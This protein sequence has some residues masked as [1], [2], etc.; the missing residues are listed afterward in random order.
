M[1][2][3]SIGRRMPT[4]AAGVL[5]VA[6]CGLAFGA[7][8]MNPTAS[9]IPFP[10]ALT[11]AEIRVVGLNSLLDDAL[12]IGNGDINALIWTDRGA[13]A[14][15]LT[16]NDV[17]DGRLLTENDPPLP[18]LSRI[19]ALGRSGKPIKDPIL[20]EGVTWSG[21]DSY[22][23]HPYPCPRACARLVLGRAGRT[24]WHAIREQGAH[25]AWQ[26]RG[27]VTVMS[28]EGNKG[29]SNGYACGPLDLSTDDY[30]R[31][32]VR[33]SGSENARYFVDVMAP[34]R[35]NV[36]N[37][38]WIDSPTEPTERVFDLPAG[39]RIGELILYTWTEDG[40][41]AENRFEAVTFEGAKGR[42][43]IDLTLT[44]PSTCAG[45]L[46]LRRAA[47]FVKGA[48][49]GPAKAEIR[50]LDDRN[51]F[52][53]R[54]PVDVQ[55]VD[56]KNK[57]LPAV[58]R[59][60]REGATWFEQTLPGDP[61]WPGMRFAV[62]LATRGDDKAVAI[63]TSSES[64]DPARAAVELARSVLAADRSQLIAQHEAGWQRFWSRSGVKLD[65]PMLQRTWYRSLYFLRC[66]SK[67]GVVSP[68]LFAGLVNDT[69]AW[70]GDYH[71]NYNIQQTFWG[72]YAANHPELAEPYDRLIREYLPRAQWLVRQVF[73]LPG[74]YYPHVLV[75]YEPTDPA[76]CKSAVGRQYI[77]HTWGM[78]IGVAGF[79]V[80]PLWWHYKYAPDRVLLAE[81]VYPPLREVA[82]FYAAFVEQCD[83]GA[84]GKVRLGPSVSPEH[85][86]WRPNLDRNYDCAF[87]IA[88]VRYTL[89]AAIEAA[90]TLERDEALVGQWR[91]ALDRLP[92]YPLHGKDKPVVVDVAG[93]PPT[94]YNIS[95]PATPV[96]PG[97][98]V[99][100]QSP[101]DERALFVRTIDGLKWN[102]NNATVMLAV[103]R[104][105][106]G[107]P[108]TQAWL[109]TEVETR[110]R[111]NGT[112]TLNRLKP[113]HH[114]ND[115]GH[116]TE[117]F[118]TGMAVSE[119]MVQSVGDVIRLFPAL[120]P[121]GTASFRDLRTQGGFVVSASCDAR[122]VRSLEITSTVGGALRLV[123]PWSS[124]EVRRAGKGDYESLTPDAA[125]V[126]RLDTRAGERLAFRQR[127]ATR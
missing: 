65:D 54:T 85:W 94:T 111:P 28:I 32:R 45:R 63:V 16:K 30:A 52:L 64:K 74:A 11:D 101:A 40:R 17:W 6:F 123:S 34:D 99:T 56:L 100:W 115:F 73:D 9:T 60:Q 42:H 91:S 48:P 82:R 41:R 7:A 95:V 89:G 81:T 127:Q 92:P 33:L 51:V 107:M 14:L 86:G 75:A 125:R 25:N 46:D 69:P 118:G 78:T 58:T 36:L 37:S 55:L 76:R 67:P 96:F 72:C 15:M 88:M 108:D 110:T 93:A 39:K 120:A 18:T 26:R 38:K 87:D 68:G 122:S 97:D 57:E 21:P 61:D 35:K 79:T 90:R 77:H 31:L 29:A 104:A 44:V 4:A 24:S 98:V 62:A 53:I 106:L 1:S 117:Q 105:R 59:G 70:H 10:E 121:K 116:Y 71:T 83:G 126:V 124:I 84:G 119:L 22:H 23:A 50:A 114:F 43:T 49:D 3:P 103:S 80:Q 112:M 27:N 102:G 5:T 66:V 2:V 12:L 109:R 113:H 20:P 47:A 8:D 19:K 13:P